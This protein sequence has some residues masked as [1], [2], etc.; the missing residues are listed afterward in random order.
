M[1]FPNIEDVKDLERMLKLH[2]DK[3][4]R[5]DD[6]GRIYIKGTSEDEMI[7]EY[8]ENFPY[9]P[10]M[11]IPRVIIC[12]DCYQELHKQTKRFTKKLEFNY[13]EQWGIDNE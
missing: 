11:K 3:Y 2:P 13:Y 1:T 8:K 10:E 9:D 7:E 12:D 6:C 4:Y 5:C